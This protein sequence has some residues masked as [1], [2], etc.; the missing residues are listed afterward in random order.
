MKRLI[1]VFTFSIILFSC[2]DSKEN[3]SEK[4]NERRVAAINDS[5]NDLRVILRKVDKAID[6]SGGNEKIVTDTIYGLPVFDTTRNESGQPILDEKGNAKFHLRG[7]Q[8][9]PDSIVIVLSTL[10]VDSLS[11]RN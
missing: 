5:L 3:E 7:W 8:Q 9:I 6:T 10:D 11:R 2:N 4:P 1:T